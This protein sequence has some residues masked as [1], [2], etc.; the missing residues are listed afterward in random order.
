L[1]SYG[2]PKRLGHGSQKT[3][4]WLPKEP[5]INLKKK[6]KKMAF[7]KGQ[8]VRMVDVECIGSGLQGNYC[9]LEC[10]QMH[11]N[12]IAKGGHAVEGSGNESKR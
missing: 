4:S 11:R 3:W 12:D 8:Q 9:A 10:R 1:L 5:L 2:S 6:K 7:E